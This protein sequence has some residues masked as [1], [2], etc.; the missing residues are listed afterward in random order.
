LKI[1]QINF[2]LLDDGAKAK[3]NKIRRS[4]LRRYRPTKILKECVSIAIEELQSD[5]K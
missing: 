1:S 4:D 2:L 5:L 3:A